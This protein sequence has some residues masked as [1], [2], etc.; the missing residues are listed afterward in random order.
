MAERNWFSIRFSS[1]GFDLLNSCTILIVQYLNTTLNNLFQSFR[2]TWSSSQRQQDMWIFVTFQ[3]LTALASMKMWFLTFLQSSLAGDHWQCCIRRGLWLVPLVPSLLATHVATSSSPSLP[4][5]P[6][7][8]YVPAT[9][10]C[11]HCLV[12][13]RQPSSPQNSPGKCCSSYLWQFWRRYLVLK[14]VKQPIIGITCHANVWQNQ[15]SVLSRI[16]KIL[17][18]TQKMWQKTNWKREYGPCVSALLLTHSC[19]DCQPVLLQRMCCFSF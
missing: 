9:R 13:Q 17:G 11:C 3:D 7:L 8:P 1:N 5:S 10:D 16:M 14:L 18:V 15:P 19:A 6:L 4:H 12:L 2:T